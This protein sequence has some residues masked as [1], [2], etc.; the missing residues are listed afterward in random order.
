[1]AGTPGTFAYW[2]KRKREARYKR[3]EDART[4]MRRLTG[5]DIGASTWAQ[6]ESGSRV[7]P[8]RN[9]KRQALIEFFGG[10]P[11]PVEPPLNSPLV[12]TDEG[13]ALLAVVA[14]MDRQ[15]TVLTALLET[16]I[17]DAKVRDARLRAID[18]ELRL[19]REQS[20]SLGSSAPPLPPGS[21]G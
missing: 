21:V 3:Q 17:Q 4:D 12:V 10:W 20:G 14:A 1:M 6:W 11:E 18:A 15:T 5:V 2:L 19:L 9:R 16:V 8:E 7:P 13:A